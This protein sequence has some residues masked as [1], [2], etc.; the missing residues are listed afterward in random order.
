MNN[1]LDKIS[2]DLRILIVDDASTIRNAVGKIC[3]DLG[4]DN[5][6]FAADGLESLKS[7][8]TAEKQENPF[9]LVLCDINM[10]ALSGLDF[11]KEVRKT[12]PDLPIIMV[13]IESDSRTVMEAITL[14][15]SHYILKPVTAEKLA[16][17]LIKILGSK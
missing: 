13:T 17:K 8:E 6:G 7:I 10:P 16:D 1:E 12:H 3:I 14:G 5:L 11:L 9:G 15:A 4:F 2:K